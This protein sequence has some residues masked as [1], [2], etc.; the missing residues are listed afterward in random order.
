MTVQISI[1]LT[2]H[3]KLWQMNSNNN[4]SLFMEMYFD[5]KFDLFK[6]TMA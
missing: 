5:I 3:L 2:R 1:K 4:A 6:V